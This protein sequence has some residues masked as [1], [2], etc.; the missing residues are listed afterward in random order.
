M[1]IPLKRR[2]AKDSQKNIDKY[3]TKTD[4][5]ILIVSHRLPVT[6]H[7]YFVCWAFCQKTMFVITTGIF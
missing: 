2:P 6:G 1:P 5:T 3:K 4:Y 7:L